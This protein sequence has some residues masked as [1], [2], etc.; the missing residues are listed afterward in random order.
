[1]GKGPPLPWHHVTNCGT[2]QYFHQHSFLGSISQAYVRVLK[3]LVLPRI[4][5]EWPEWQ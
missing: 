5:S 2:V 4:S 3:S 1:M